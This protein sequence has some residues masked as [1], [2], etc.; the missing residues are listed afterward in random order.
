[1]MKRVNR[2]FAVV[3]VGLFVQSG[4]T[5]NEFNKDSA[6]QEAKVITKSFAG[7]LKKELV[8]AMGDGGPINALEVCNVKAMPISADAT[9]NSDAMVSRVSLK[10]RNPL[11]IPNEWQELVLKDFDQRAAAGENV[12]SMAS[13][14]VVKL[15]SGK[16]Q[17]RFMKALPTG[18]VCL[19]CHGQQIDASV[20][21]RLNEL[22]PADRATGY[23]VG[24]VRG[25]IVVIKD[26]E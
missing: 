24:E 16:H 23:S 4:A 3:A 26:Y 10:N 21:S 15:D 7:S 19:A 12:E 2:I 20:K 18:G 5:A 25:A 6:V 13:A 17:L 9:S 14:Q 1:M 11:N 22:Y 8:A